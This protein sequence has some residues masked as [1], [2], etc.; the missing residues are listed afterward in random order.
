VEWYYSSGI[1]GRFDHGKLFGVALPTFCDYEGFLVYSGQIVEGVKLTDNK[2]SILKRLGKPAKI[3]SDPLE[4]GTEP[5][6]PVVW[7]KESRYYWRFKD[8]TLEATFLEQAQS[9]SAVRHLTWPKDGLTS[10]YVKK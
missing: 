6:V 9:V 8:Y 1:V 7:P 5:N 3:E 10:I 4:K 2:E